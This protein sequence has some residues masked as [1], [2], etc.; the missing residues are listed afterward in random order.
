MVPPIPIG[1][2]ALGVFA[3]IEPCTLGVEACTG[4]FYWQSQFEE[5][6]PTVKVIS[7]QYVKPFIKGKRTILMMPEVS[8]WPC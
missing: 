6:G 7:P 2:I 8:L 5:F 1:E 3:R 4:A